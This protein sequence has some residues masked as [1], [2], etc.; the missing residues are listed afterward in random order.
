MELQYRKCVSLNSIEKYDCRTSYDGTLY[1]LAAYSALRIV[2]QLYIS[3]KHEVLEDAGPE[4]RDPTRDR[5]ASSS[6]TR[7]TELQ[8]AVKLK[9]DRPEGRTP[10]HATST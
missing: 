6:L 8:Y 4:S 1:A 7:P 9:G 10:L 5:R 3:I 2:I